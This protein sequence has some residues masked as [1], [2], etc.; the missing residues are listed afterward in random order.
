MSGAAIRE[1]HFL[2]A[3]QGKLEKPLGDTKILPG[4][5]PGLVCSFDP[6]NGVLVIEDS[7]KI[8][9][10]ISPVLKAGVVFVPLPA[11]V[12]VVG[13]R[14]P[15]RDRF[16]VV[17]A[18]RTGTPMKGTKVHEVHDVTDKL[19][20]GLTWWVSAMTLDPW[21]SLIGWKEGLYIDPRTGLRADAT[22]IPPPSNVSPILT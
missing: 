1:G 20:E 8:L 13:K 4:P 21:H 9:T 2:H 14:A 5:W 3:I 7:A 12:R 22:L 6:K 19:G 17:E 10:K 16:A 15:K 11:E 18:M